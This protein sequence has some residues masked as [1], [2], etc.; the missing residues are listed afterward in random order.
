MFCQVKKCSSRIQRVTD[1]DETSL[2][3]QVSYHTAPWSEG[4]GSKMGDPGIEV[5]MKLAF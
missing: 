1:F 5:V 3:P 2:V 4:P